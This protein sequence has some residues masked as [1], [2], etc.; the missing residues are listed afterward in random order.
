MLIYFI[1]SR[2]L[3]LNQTLSD[4]WK[5]CEY[6]LP[7]I[8][9]RRNKICHKADLSS[10][11][12]HK[13]TFMFWD[14]YSGVV[15]GSILVW[16]SNWAWCLVDDWPLNA[17]LFQLTSPAIYLYISCYH[18]M[19]GISYKP[20][21]MKELQSFT[22]GTAYPV[23]IKSQENG[24]LKSYVFL[25]I[26]KWKKKKI[27]YAFYCARKTRQPSK[28]MIVCVCVWMC[29]WEIHRNVTPLGAFN[30]LC[31]KTLW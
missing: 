21:K 9:K 8:H 24:I 13:L 4:W 26:L 28:T 16:Y 20:F 23:T 25:I 30:L 22:S 15:E 2:L 11:L 7:I 1:S 12:C 29:T 10:Q 5:L 27:K 31:V 19:S 14:F 6:F 3:G 18:V 17:R